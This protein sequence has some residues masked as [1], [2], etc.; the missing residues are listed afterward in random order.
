MRESETELVFD[1]GSLNP[2]YSYFDDIDKEHEVWYLDA[3]TAYNQLA[4][5]ESL[6]IGNISLWRMGSE[7]PS[8]WNIM[9]KSATSENTKNLNSFEYGYEIDYEG[10]G[11]F[12]KL[13]SIPVI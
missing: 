8:I 6:G 3:V 7:D 12:Y 4:S 9:K 2:M 10:K 11:E 13:Q 1:T 5:V